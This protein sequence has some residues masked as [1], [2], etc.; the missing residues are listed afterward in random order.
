MIDPAASGLVASRFR[1]EREVGRGA[2]GIVYRA[3]DAV[4][5]IAVALKV[6]SAAGA[7][8][9]EQARFEREGQVLS[10][11]DH[12]GIV[13]VVAF[14]SLE[15]P[16][17]DGLG[18]RLETGSPYIAMEWLEGEDLQARQRRAPLTLRQSLEVGR[19]VAHALG[20]AHD[21][22]VVHRDI[23]PSNIFLIGAGAT[24][25]AATP[26]RRRASSP[27]RRFARR[28]VPRLPE[29]PAARSS[30]SPPCGWCSRRCTCRAPSWSTSGWRRRATCGS[31][32]PAR[33]WARRRTWRR[34]RPAATARPTR[35]AT[36]TR[37]APRSSSS[38]PGARRTSG[39]TP[40]RPW[41]AW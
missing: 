13:R 8:A 20:A 2:A 41:P 35:G 25:R 31:P 18:R 32:A 17:P 3:G 33:W 29:S 6:I 34:S 10:E 40:S 5:G 1:I 19:Q 39:P 14:G 16:C 26:S 11:L 24:G 36:S 21:A 28:T 23:K 22:G 7:D 4:T 15:T 37:S 9:A 27:P 12:P 30:T 38:S